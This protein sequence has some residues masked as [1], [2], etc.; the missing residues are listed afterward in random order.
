MKTFEDR[1]F[2]TIWETTRACDLVC[3]H[4]RADACKDRDPAELTTAQGKRL[5]DDLAAGGVPLVVLTGGDPAKRQDL[6]ELVAHGTSRGISMAL[7]P[8][9]TPLVT[10]ELIRE[11]AGAGLTRLAISIDGPDAAVHDGFRGVAGGFDCALRILA[12]AKGCGLSTQ[13]NTSVHTG[14][15]GLLPELTALVQTLG[16]SLWSVFVVVRTGRATD[17]MVL[18]AERVEQLL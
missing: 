16:V 11:L 6:V 17:S 12:T 9:A 15:I 5:L 1:P 8:S 3:K 14:N 18:S 13:V 4:C 2:I 10:D 7:T